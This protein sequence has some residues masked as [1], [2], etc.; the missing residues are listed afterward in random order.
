MSVR[1]VDG[2]IF[3]EGNCPVE[4]AEHL[5]ALLQGGTRHEVDLTNAGHLHTATVQVLFAMRPRIVGDFADSFQSRWLGPPLN[6]STG[7]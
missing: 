4:D 7:G 5:L 1:F 3:L 6:H 2:V